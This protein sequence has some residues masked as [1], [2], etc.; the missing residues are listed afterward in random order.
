MFINIDAAIDRQLEIREASMP[1]WVN[2]VE[3]GCPRLDRVMQIRADEEGDQV[4]CIDKAGRY[5]DE[6]SKK[7]VAEEDV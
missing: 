5:W 4:L 1:E 2:W 7:R 3:G 6:T